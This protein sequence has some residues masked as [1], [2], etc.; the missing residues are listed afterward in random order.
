MVGE[1]VSASVVE[2]GIVGI[3]T[4][5]GT[6]AGIGGVPGGSRGI[7]MGKGADAEGPGFLF[8]KVL[9]ENNLDI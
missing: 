4:A 3:S 5:V 7:A 1:G 9:N 6:G 8:G 2:V